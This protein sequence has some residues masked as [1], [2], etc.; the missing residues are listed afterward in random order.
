MTCEVTGLSLC[1][2]HERKYD[3]FAPSPDKIVPSLGYVPGN[4][5]IVAAIYNRMRGSNATDEEILV[6]AKALI[7]RN[8]Q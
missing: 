7:E 2:D 3:P 5:R 8:S 4:V 6:F 1:W